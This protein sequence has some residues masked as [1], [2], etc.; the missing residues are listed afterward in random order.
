MTS[1]DFVLCG[2][3]FPGLDVFGAVANGFLSSLLCECGFVF[4]IFL[5]NLCKVGKC[6]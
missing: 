6:F 5:R 1:A 4:F 3:D 2:K